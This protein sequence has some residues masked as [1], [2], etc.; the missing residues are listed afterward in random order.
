MTEIASVGG[1]VLGGCCGT[2]P[3]HIKALVD[4]TK[5]LPTPNVLLKSAPL[6]RLIP[7]PLSLAK[8]PF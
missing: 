1:T 3:D 6:F 2:T 4:S 8:L 7:T 5:A